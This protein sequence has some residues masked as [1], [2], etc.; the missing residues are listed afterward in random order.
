MAY[1]DGWVLVV[2]RRKVDAYRRMA[3]KAGRVWREHG[4]LQ[5][6]ECM[7]DDMDTKG[8]GVPFPRFARAKAG[9]VVFF[10]YVVYR[11]RAH[12]D[13]VNKRVMKD[14]RMAEMPPDMPFDAK[15]MAYGGFRVV[16]EA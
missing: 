14:K 5:F 16:V 2:P 10:S 1:V 12:R 15:R 7:G 4:A 9:E 11:S 3:K 13:A 6:R 8:M